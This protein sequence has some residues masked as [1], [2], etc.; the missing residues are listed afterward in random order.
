MK[1]INIHNLP[2]MF[3][4]SIFRVF[5]FMLYIVAIIYGIIDISN[6]IYFGGVMLLLCML[7]LFIVAPPW[8]MNVMYIGNGYIEVHIMGENIYYKNYIMNIG[9]ERYYK[10]KFSMSE[11]SQYGFS[12]ELCGRRHMYFTTLHTG[13]SLEL[14]FILKNGKVISYDPTL[15][16]PE[17]YKNLVEYIRNETG[18]EPSEKLNGYFNNTPNFNLKEF[19]HSERLWD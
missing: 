10:N 1:N 3:S 13:I 19:M 5:C 18:I 9:R 8:R 2:Y 16:K 14:V 11:L 4:I 6:G 17:G 15:I 12:R 7:Y